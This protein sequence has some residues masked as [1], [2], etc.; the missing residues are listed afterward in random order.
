MQEGRPAL[1]QYIDIKS[2]ERRH[3]SH[4]DSPAADHRIA[5]LTDGLAAASF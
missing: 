2:E 3:G 1:N 4:L 5:W